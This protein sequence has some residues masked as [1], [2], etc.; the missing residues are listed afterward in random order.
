MLCSTAA[1]GRKGL[2]EVSSVLMESRTAS[3]QE[4]CLLSFF[5]PVL[6]AEAKTHNQEDFN[7]NLPACLIFQLEE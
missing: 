2:A 1:S 7:D 4:N 5:T 3:M 6:A